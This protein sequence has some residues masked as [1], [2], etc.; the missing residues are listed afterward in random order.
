[1]KRFLPLGLVVSLFGLGLPVLTGCRTLPD[2]QPSVTAA[3]VRA[4][5]AAAVLPE[6]LS[7]QSPDGTIETL[8]Q[9]AGPLKYSISVDGQPII[10]DATLGLEFRGGIT[11]G[12]D[13]EY[14]SADRSEADGQWT[15]LLGG[16]RSP[17]RDRHNELV[18]HLREQG[19]QR[20]FT[21]AFRAFDDGVGFRYLLPRG[22]GLDAFVLE[23]E[24][25]QFA[26]TADH[27]AWFGAQKGGFR[28]PQEWEFNPGKL[29]DI[30]ADSI[31]GCPV[32]V[33]TKTAWVA[34]TESDLLDWAGLWFSAAPAANPK[35]PVL[36]ARLAPRLDGEGLVKAQ[37]PH[38]SP[39]RVLMIG[40]K[41]GD[42][43]ES[44]IV[45]NLATPPQQ[46]WDVVRSNS[47]THHTWSFVQPGKM[48]WDHWW[49]GDEQMDTATLQQ[50]IQLAADMGWRYMLIDWWWYGEPNKPESDLR[51]IHPKV[52][53]DAVRTFARERNVGLWLWVRF[54]DLERFEQAEAVFERFRQ[55]GIAGVKIDFMDRDDQEMVNWYERIT[56][57][58][59]DAGLMINFHGAYKPTGMNRTYPNQVTREGILGNEYNKWS[60]RVTPEHKVTLPFTRFLCGP[61]DFTPGG[62]LNR[63]PD[64]FE[65]G[66]PAKVQGTRAAELALFVLYDSPLC[67]VCDHPDHYR[68]QAGAEFL[69]LVPTTWADTRVLEAQVADYLVMLREST[70]KRFT[71]SPTVP[72]PDYYLAGLTDATS[73]EV[74][75]KLDFLPRGRWQLELWRDGPVTDTDAD[76]LEKDTRFVTAADTLRIRMA[77][78][79][80][81]AARLVWS[82]PETGP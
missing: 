59:A 67:C 70:T 53:L 35:V 56:A 75:V 39:W 78:A 36:A 37:T 34:L 57:A 64:K 77:P 74:E 69:K 76:V 71:Y 33:Q 45:M 55:W 65:K 16:K 1:M 5:M 51:T 29:S 31:I 43:I 72:V 40:R 41:P 19:T 3:P 10:R 27:T 48:A 8:I 38:R 30:E 13:V 46:S 15:D 44:D 24:L 79:G 4:G 42:L 58:A 28:G 62:F 32:L 2:T 14:L 61:A 80:G 7:L 81:F 63:Q 73:R 6:T 26:F 22:T 9:C 66:K 20:R 21:V 11:L 52:D 68:D 60:T 50:Y 17:I 18:L 82:G 23:K 47:V 12:A 54:N 49:S 25:S